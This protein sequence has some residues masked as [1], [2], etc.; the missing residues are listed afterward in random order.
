MKGEKIVIGISGGVDSA[1]SVK[2][3]Q[4]EGYDV[5]AVMLDMC[6]GSPDEAR[7]L[8][9][10]LDV[11]VIY[12]NVRADFEHEVV[13]AFF[14]TL[15]NGRTP[16]PCTVCNP[17]VKWHHIV[18]TARRVGAS[19]WASGHYCRITEH[20]GKKYVTRGVDALKDQSYYLWRLDEEILSGMV[21]PLGGM[22]KS[23]VKELAAEMGLESI[24]A[25]RES[26]SVCFFGSGGYG[27]L[28]EKRV[29]MSKYEN[30][31]VV[32]ESGAVV[33]RHKGA[34]LYTIGQRK[35]LDI[36]KGMCVTRIDARNNRL[37]VGESENL[38]TD[39]MTLSELVIR[40]E[41]EFFSSDRMS[42]VVRGIGRNPDGFVTVERVGDG[43]VT[44]KMQGRG[45][46]GVC[47]GQPSV[48]YIGD[49]VVGGGIVMES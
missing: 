26:M 9:E 22:L 5:T 18:E 39:T 32:D 8:G 33:G 10:L 3:L 15:L 25:K 17:A 4:A 1:V 49:R 29:D 47:P 28:F 20:G 44:V 34:F 2:L 38:Y 36:P 46:W 21:L 6:G 40:D 48:F 42:V 19:K 43:K 45:A 41:S 24:A 16:S 11:E 14:D 30:G 12:E 13:D 23:H 35:G 27:S 7:L 37:T 31:E